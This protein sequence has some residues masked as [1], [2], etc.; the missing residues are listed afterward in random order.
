MEP[1][2]NEGVPVAELAE[3]DDLKKTRLEILESSKL[4]NE[5]IENDRE[6]VLYGW[7]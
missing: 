7:F 1:Q 6:E 4:L 5:A 3:K 2:E